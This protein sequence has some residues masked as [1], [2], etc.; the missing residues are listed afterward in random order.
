[1]TSISD[2]LYLGRYPLHR[3][4]SSEWTALITRCKG[5][6]AKDG[7][8]NL[9]RFLRPEVAASVAQHFA[10]M[11]ETESFRHERS[12]NIYFKRQIDGLAPDHPALTQF[13]TA[14]RTLCADQFADGPLITL[15]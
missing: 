4:D 10:P 5:D 9:D 1:M 3:P 14:N 15:Y 12:H 2:I 8:F 7:M 6:L 13:Q 11:F